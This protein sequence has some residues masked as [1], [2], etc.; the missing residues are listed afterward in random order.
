MTVTP[1]GNNWQLKDISSDTRE[2]FNLKLKPANFRWCYP[3][4]NQLDEANG[5]LWRSVPARATRADAAVARARGA[6]DGEKWG[7]QV[8][9]E[10]LRLVA[11]D[12]NSNQKQNT[13][14]LLFKYR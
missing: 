8:E 9:K 11:T 2:R 14:V 12:A 1:A 5:A 13:F 3:N 10:G 6:D 4:Y 7:K